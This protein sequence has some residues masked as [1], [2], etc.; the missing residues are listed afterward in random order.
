MNIL[1]T[2]SNGFVGK[3]LIENLNNIKTKKNQTRP[4]LHID[5]I[6]S[7]D[8]NTAPELLGYYCKITD[9]VLDRKSV[10]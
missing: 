1:I 6:L 9:F 7:Y 5:Q 2:G 10:V 8:T 4:N 3:N